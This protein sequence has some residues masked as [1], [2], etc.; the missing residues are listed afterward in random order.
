MASRPSAHPSPQARRQAQLQGLQ[1][2]LASHNEQLVARLLGQWVHRHGLSSL[3]TLWAEL[4]ELEPEGCTWWHEHSEA[5][6]QPEPAPSLHS[7]PIQALA[8]TPAARPLSLAPP[9][10]PATRPAPAPSHP[11]L[12]Q[13]R[14]WLPDQENRRAA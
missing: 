14:A 11:A 3:A 5:V 4:S 7:L 10:P 8:S 2:S 1:A 6:A 13:L 9:V 12:V